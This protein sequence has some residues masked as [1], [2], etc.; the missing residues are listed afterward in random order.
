MFTGYLFS[1]VNMVSFILLT[2]GN[3]AISANNLLTDLH[4]FEFPF[5][6]DGET[7]MLNCDESEFCD[8]SFHIFGY[9]ARELLTYEYLKYDNVI[10][11]NNEEHISSFVVS[12][13]K[14]NKTMI[15]WPF[16]QKIDRHTIYISLDITIKLKDTDIT[17]YT[18]HRK[19][20]AIHP[21]D[22]GI[23]PYNQTVHNTRPVLLKMDF[24]EM[25]TANFD[26]CIQQA[27]KLLSEGYLSSVSGISLD[28]MVQYLEDLPTVPGVTKIH[29]AISSDPRVAA[30]AAYYIPETIV[31]KVIVHVLLTIVLLIV[32]VVVVSSVSQRG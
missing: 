2:K 28:A 11:I 22:V 20:I 8:F 23:R 17:V 25:G 9:L 7:V 19:L 24:I 21:S 26:T 5:P 3:S 4:T 10:R 27:Q 32:V 16:Q 18:S 30:L 14:E 6:R 13:V 29:S 31:N 12:G 15:T 1:L